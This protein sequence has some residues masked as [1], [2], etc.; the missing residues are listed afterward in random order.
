MGYE[1]SFSQSVAGA[2]R[3][4]MSRKRKTSNELATILH[5]SQSSASRRMTGDVSLSLDEISAIADWLDLP[6]ERLLMPEVRIASS[7]QA[8]A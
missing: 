2:L 3:A 5:L 1:S 8:I 7:K 6:I 4:E